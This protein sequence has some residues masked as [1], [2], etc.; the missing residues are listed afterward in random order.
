MPRP[1]SRS[2]PDGGGQRGQSNLLDTVG[3]DTHKRTEGQP[4]LQ[5]AGVLGAF[6]IDWVPVTVGYRWS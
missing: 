4:L 2:V 5:R 6:E 3:G 1:T